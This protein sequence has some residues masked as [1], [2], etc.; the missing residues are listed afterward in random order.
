MPPWKSPAVVCAGRCGF[1]SPR[2]PSPC[3]CAGAGCASTSRAAMPRSTWCSRAMP[4]T[5][6][7]RAARLPQRRRQRQRHAPPLLPAPAAPIFSAL[8]KRGRTS[9]SCAMARS[10]TRRL[11]KPSATIWT[12]AGARVG[13][14]RRD[15][16]RSMPGNRR[17]LPDRWPLIPGRGRSNLPAQ[18]RSCRV[19]SDR[20]DL[21]GI[22]PR[23]A[24]AVD[25]EDAA[26]RRFG[27]RRDSGRW[28][29]VALHWAIFPIIA[30]PRHLSSSSFPAIVLVDHHR[31]AAG[32]ACWSPSSALSTRRCMKAPGLDA[33]AEFR[34][35][36]RR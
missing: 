1:A 8:R 28:P 32:R 35:A 16:C 25:R 9:S 26:L 6:R 4:I 11:P 19:A 13:L 7:W 29:R 21:Q 33:G 34:R 30:G 12:D 5:H 17:P 23:T 22:P 3:A 31:R 24:V 18:H 27:F 14:D 15:R 2:N 36:G 10:M 20:P